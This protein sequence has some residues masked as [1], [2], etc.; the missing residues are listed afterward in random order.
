MMKVRVRVGVRLRVRVGVGVRVRVGVGVRV[1]VGVG[2]GVGVGVSVGEGAPLA[3]KTASGKPVRAA[4]SYV[5]TYLPVATSA[6]TSAC[7]SGDATMRPVVGEM[8]TVR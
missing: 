4:S 1:R 8:D 6:S 7:S 3:A 2:V 5:R